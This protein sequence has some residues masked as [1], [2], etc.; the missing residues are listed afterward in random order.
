[1]ERNHGTHQDRP[2]KKM[3]RIK[4][5]SY[6]TADEYLEGEYLSGHNRRFAHA[7]AVPENYHRQAPSGVEVDEVFRL[8]TER[9]IGND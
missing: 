3:R 7:A 8:E 2:V 4:T 5:G 9:V 1:M 6:E